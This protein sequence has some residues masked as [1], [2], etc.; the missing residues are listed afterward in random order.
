MRYGSSFLVDMFKSYSR[1]CFFCSFFCFKHTYTHTYFRDESFLSKEGK[2]LN[3]V[4]N[5]SNWLSPA[6]IRAHTDMGQADTSVVGF[7]QF[8]GSQMR[9]IV[10]PPAGHSVF[11]TVSGWRTNSWSE[12]FARLNSYISYLLLNTMAR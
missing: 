9:L 4:G 12:C 7:A 3:K 10:L 6:G 2:R 11:S 8:A 1:V 5:V